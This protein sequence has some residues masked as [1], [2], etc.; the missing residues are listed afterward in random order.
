MRQLLVLF[1]LL[2]CQA[3]TDESS[4]A[5]Q[6]L[7]VPAASGS[8]EP[9]L[10]AGLDGT[11]LLSW[12][13]PAGDEHAL[14]FAA[15]ADSGWSEPLTV[16]QS[17]NWFINWADFPSVVPL[18]NGLWAAHW[19]HKTPGSVYSYDVQVA[20][21][22]DQGLSWS[23][24]RTP[25]TDGTHTE[26][27]FASLFP[28]AD[29]LGAVW[30][31]GRKTAGADHSDPAAHDTGS[32]DSGM[33]LRSAVMSGDL[34]LLADQEIDPLVCD[35]CQTD[36]ALSSTGPLLVY[37][38]RS[39]DEIRDI[40]ISRHLDGTWQEGEP[41]A[42]DGW[43]IGG[44]PVNGPAIAA[45]GELVVV[46]WFTAANGTS[47][48]KVAF[49]T[50]AGE[51]FSEPVLVDSSKVLG[52]VGVSLLP[53]GDA[54]I[55]WLKNISNGRAEIRL[56][57]IKPD[58]TSGTMTVVAET[59]AARISGFPQ[60][61]ATEGALLLAWTDITESVKSVRSARIAFDAL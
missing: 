43:K 24:S 9:N 51:S 35:C 23:E 6:E 34:Q 12:L 56:Q 21:S 44:C 18:A 11:V 42:V 58:G 54:A 4:V 49:S 27:G 22:R 45:R 14:R 41:V 32:P 15:L 13:E 25:H 1:A 40:Y 17:D 33:T 50:N 61:L 30:L 55:S 39:P 37:R 52:R 10:A 36:V 60:L 31:D 2:T 38:D 5:I 28:V 26:H 47:R 48:V 8:A 29:G 57:R 53:D 46:A 16:A 20:V 3:C 19:L 59:A 7:P